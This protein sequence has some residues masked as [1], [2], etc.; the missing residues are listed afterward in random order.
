MSPT[1]VTIINKDSEGDCMLLSVRCGK[2]TARSVAPSRA[3][4]NRNG[5]KTGAG[6]CW[7]KHRQRIPER[8]GPGPSL[9]FPALLLTAVASETPLCMSVSGLSGCVCRLKEFPIL[10]AQAICTHHTLKYA[11]KGV[12]INK[13]A[14]VKTVTHG[15]SRLSQKWEQ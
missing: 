4:G 13:T 9:G 12:K 1:P 8:S 6:A 5:G 10:W 7:V 15:T 3:L 14:L 2:T 11:P